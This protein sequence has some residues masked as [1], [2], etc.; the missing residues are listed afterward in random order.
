[1]NLYT[2]QDATHTRLCLINKNNP[3]VLGEITTLLG[4]H[5]VN[6]VQ[7]LNT[8]RD[9]IAYTVIDMQD[10]PKDGAPAQAMQEQILAI[11]D[12]LSTRLIWTGRATE[13][14]T[15]FYTKSSHSM[16]G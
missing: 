10:Y 11:P 12:V 15:H 2:H 14:P 13:G 1:M 5:G 6:I 4:K 16:D 7:Q 8:S 3:G 9:A